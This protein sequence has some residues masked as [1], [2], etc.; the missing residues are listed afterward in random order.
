M[1]MKLGMASLC[2]AVCHVSAPVLYSVQ[3]HFEPIEA[4]YIEMKYQATF[5]HLN[6][7]LNE[8]Y[9]LCQPPSP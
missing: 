8:L 3:C 7:V 9:D 1:I 4:C 2:L 5:S 6:V